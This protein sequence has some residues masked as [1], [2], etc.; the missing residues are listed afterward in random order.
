MERTDG[1]ERGPGV[2]ADVIMV[3]PDEA[4]EALNAGWP[5]NRII[6]PTIVQVEGLIWKKMIITWWALEVIAN[7][8]ILDRIHNDSIRQGGTVIIDNPTR[9]RMEL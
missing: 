4:Q 2:M 5:V 1:E 8:K 9:A 3:H 6:Y 7:S